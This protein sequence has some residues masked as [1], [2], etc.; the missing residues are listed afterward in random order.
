[1]AGI[2]AFL[3][4]EWLFGMS[5]QIGFYF[6]FLPVAGLATALLAFN[7]KAYLAGFDAERAHA[8]A[9]AKHIEREQSRKRIE[10]AVNNRDIE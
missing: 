6:A 2:I 1:M 4:A 7:W 8:R 10:E 9:I 3:T 5:P